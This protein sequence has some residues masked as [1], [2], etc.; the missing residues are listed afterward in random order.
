[1][2]LVVTP[3][4]AIGCPSLEELHLK[5]CKRHDDDLYLLSAPGLRGVLVNFL[6]KMCQL[7]AP[8]LQYFEDDG[9]SRSSHDYCVA[10]L[11]STYEARIDISGDYPYTIEIMES[12][13]GVG[14]RHLA[15]YQG[16]EQVVVEGTRFLNLSRLEVYV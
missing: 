16:P 15:E 11:N 14:I 4:R 5:F 7:D 9:Y 6:Y 12:L 13:E 8:S 1:M 2:R 10:N 3:G